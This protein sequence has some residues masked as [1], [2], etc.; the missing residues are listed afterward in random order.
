LELLLDSLAQPKPRTKTLK[1]NNNI[2]I[3]TPLKV[4]QT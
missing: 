2:F 3:K 1:L 4:T